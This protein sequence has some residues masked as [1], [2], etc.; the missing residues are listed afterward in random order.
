MRAKFF[1]PEASTFHMTR[2]LT[3]RVRTPRSSLPPSARRRHPQTSLA[4][5]VPTRS[6]Y[7]AIRIHSR[8]CDPR[9]PP[10]CGEPT[11]SAG[12]PSGGGWRSARRAPTTA[13]SRSTAG[14]GSRSRSCL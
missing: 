12:T 5:L 11:W 2:L 4:A 3:R 14:T 1:G 9:S 7:P 6:G 8:R 10:R 13:Y